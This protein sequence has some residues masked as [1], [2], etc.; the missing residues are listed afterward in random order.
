MPRELVFDGD[1][2]EEV[3]RH[4][5]PH[6]LRGGVHPGAPGDDAVI[7][8]ELASGELVDINKGDLVVV[9]D[10]AQAVHV[11]KEKK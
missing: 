7:K 10:E 11:V 2:H 5:H 4:L 9:D 6:A 1:N 8:V 3:L